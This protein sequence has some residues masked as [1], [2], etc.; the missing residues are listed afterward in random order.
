MTNLAVTYNKQPQVQPPQT[1]QHGQA[2]K[3]GKL[4]R[5]EKVL[6]SAF[7]LFL[8]YASI[9]MITNKSELYQVNRQEADLRVKVQQK[10]KSNA[11]LKAQVEQ[12]SRYERIAEKAKSMGM[13]INASNVQKLK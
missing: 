7:V 6:Y 9:T 1:P 3:K 8:L 12:L 10:Q 2:V 5:L 13:E 4:T 11:D